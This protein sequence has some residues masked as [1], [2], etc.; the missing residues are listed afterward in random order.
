MG[1]IVLPGSLANNW[2]YVRQRQNLAYRNLRFVPFKY[3][4]AVWPQHPKRL[5][6]SGAEVRTPRF[7]IQAPVFFTHPGSLAHTLQMWRIKHHNRKR[8]ISERQRTEISNQVRTDNQATTVAQGMRF[9][10]DI[11]EYAA[12]VLFVEP[13]HTGATTHVQNGL[14]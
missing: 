7:F 12:G 5:F 10:A 11:S 4:Y 14:L 6:E 3:E 1:F 9:G 2:F 8:R 13:E